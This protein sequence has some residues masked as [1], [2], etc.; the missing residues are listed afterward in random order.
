[1]EHIL[2]KCAACFYTVK[3]SVLNQL[4]LSRPYWSHVYSVRVQFTLKILLCVN[5]KLL[6]HLFSLRACPLLC[7]ITICNLGQ[8]SVS[9]LTDIL[10]Y[11]KGLDQLSNSD[12]RAHQLANWET[13]FALAHR[14]LGRT[15]IG[16]ISCLMTSHRSVCFSVMAGNE[17][18]AE[19]SQC[20][21]ALLSQLEV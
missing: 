8:S 11:R 1:M 19:V 20:W 21:I 9:T 14:R 3:W 12:I 15:Q 17:G 18:T 5:V 10:N 13:R 2:L 6:L 16:V 4:L 7:E